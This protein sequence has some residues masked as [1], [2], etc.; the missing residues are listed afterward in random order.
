MHAAWIRLPEAALLLESC[1]ACPPPVRILR[2]DHGGYEPVYCSTTGPGAD[3]RVAALRRI[4]QAEWRRLLGAYGLG[5]ASRDACVAHLEL[6][7]QAA[8]RAAVA[9][10]CRLEAAE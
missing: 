2:A 5:E 4:H 7:V 6:D 1:A 9:A 3:R 8:V 10:P